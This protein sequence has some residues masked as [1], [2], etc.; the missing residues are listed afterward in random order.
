[1]YNINDKSEVIKEIKR[2]LYAIST[3]TRPEIGRTTIDGYYDKETE[4]IVKNYQSAIG[5]LE[6]GVVDYITFQSIAD[7]YLKIKENEELRQTLLL[8][9]G[10]PL[11]RG[12]ASEDVRLINILISALREIYKDIPFVG[13]SNYFSRN[14]ERAVRLLREIFIMRDSPEVDTELY[15]RMIIEVDAE[16]RKKKT[17]DLKGLAWA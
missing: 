2:Y 9:T 15:N 12:M 8:P 16:N 4:R 6:S 13:N 10:F 7:E 11:S 17:N 1:M 3:T 14:T 5:I